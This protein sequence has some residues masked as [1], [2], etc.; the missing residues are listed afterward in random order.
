MYKR[1]ETG[2]FQWPRTESELR[3]LTG[4]QYRWLTEGL[5]IEQKKT[6]PKV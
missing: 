5:S 1:L 4:K 2:K 6:I 3:E